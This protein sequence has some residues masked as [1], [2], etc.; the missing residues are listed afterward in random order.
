[1]NYFSEPISETVWDIKYRYRRDK[2]MDRTIEDTWQR[3]AKAVAKAEDPTN[4]A[5]WQKQF[6]NILE[7]FQ[8]LPGGRILAGA[9]TKHSVTLFNCFVMPVNDSLKSIFGALKDGALTLQEGGGVGYDFST[10]RPSGFVVKHAGATA[11]GPVSF[12]RIWNSMCA[13]MQST[14]Q[15]AA[16]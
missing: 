7:N 14:A 16:R 5:H 10:L 13:T 4:R 9:G 1:M 12:M 11:S 6:Y 3:V 15:D 2:V 8:F